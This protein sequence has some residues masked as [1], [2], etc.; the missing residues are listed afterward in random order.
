M[1]VIY[2]TFCVYM[3]YLIGKNTYNEK[4]GRIGAILM[5]FFVNN[6]SYNGE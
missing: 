4:V 3:I 1:N 6:Y 2:E 5:A